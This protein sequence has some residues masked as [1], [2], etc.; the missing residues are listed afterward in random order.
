MAF[1]RPRALMS[2][3]SSLV[4]AAVAPL[5]LL[6]PALLRR[7]VSTQDEGQLLAYPD[8]ILRGYW[9]NTDFS[10]VYGVNNLWTLTGAFEIFGESVMV[11]R[12][13]GLLFRVVIVIVVTDMVRRVSGVVVAL[14]AGWTSVLIFASIG[15]DAFA[16]INA[17]AVGLVA[18]WL[19]ANLST[20]RAWLASGLPW[21]FCGLAIG[22]R[23]DIALACVAAVA[24]ARMLRPPPRAVGPALA[25]LVLGLSPVLL[26]VLTADNVIRDTVVNPIL[27][28]GGRRLPLVPDDHSILSY[29]L[30]VFAALGIVALTLALLRSQYRES[31]Y[32]NLAALGAFSVFLVPQMLQR[33]DT[34]HL[35]YVACIIL[36]TGLAASALL[37][38]ARWNAP[39]TSRSIKVAG[40]LA[41]VIAVGL[42][43]VSVVP[44][45]LEP[46]REARYVYATGDSNSVE[47]DNAGRSVVVSADE[48]PALNALLSTVASYVSSTCDRLFAGPSDLRYA[49]YGD[50]YI[51]FLLPDLVPATRYLEFNPGEANAD[52]SSLAADLQTADIVVLNDL[53]PPTEDNDSQRPGPQAPNDVIAE[54][55][56]KVAAFG[57]RTL[58]VGSDC[59][60]N[61]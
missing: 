27:R 28:G 13:I 26:H 20:P 35:A 5:L 59:T 31:N 14:A 60:S 51:Y 6:A 54:R 18:V 9:P 29:E 17:V 10:Y 40:V 23:L 50:T 2:R 24:V 43:G 25:G 11:E 37:V 38:R 44:T 55:F 22:F 56:T 41:A 4:I 21:G 47:V 45:M 3:P 58:L 19:A 34:I 57:D 16:W 15:L 39:T 52:D 12:L 1:D 46:L 33:L 8:L 48:G 30:L 32:R 49:H 42:A 36:P 53:G 7:P 61:S